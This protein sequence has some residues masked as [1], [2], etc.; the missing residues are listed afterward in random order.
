[1]ENTLP[2]YQVDAFTTR[3]FRGNPAAVCLTQQPLNRRTLQAIAAEMNLSETAFVHPL[4]DQPVAKARTFSL[5]WFT[6][7]TEVR[8]CGHATLATAAVLFRE[9]QVTANEIRFE[10]R[11]G[12]LLA[13]RVEAGI[14]LEFP[15]D[16]PRPW[17]M[18]P[19]VGVALGVTAADVEATAYAP[20]TR[21][22]LIHL[23]SA[24]LLRA[25]TP[26]FAK[27]GAVTA[28]ANVHGPVVTAA[29]DPPYD[30]ISRYFA[31][32]IGIN[33]DPVTGSAHTVLGPYW[34]GRLNKTEFFAYQASERGGEL[35]VSLM[36]EGRVLLVGEAV[37]VAG[38]LLYL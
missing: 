33:E 26:D 10:T 22:L 18:P 20:Q 8:L 23:K 3:P 14:A 6:P 31:P 28:A 34:G 19:D 36:P 9:L 12:G 32:A 37:I 29:G 27:L 21:N 11:S 24:A 4:D 25:L 5:R 17:E 13:R 2:F 7:T 38:G 16:P 30:F 15:A 1:M 35:H